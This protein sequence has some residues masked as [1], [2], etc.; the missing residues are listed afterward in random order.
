M[1]NETCWWDSI[2]GE[3]E[4]KFWERVDRSSPSDF[5]KAILLKDALDGRG[6]PINTGNLSG[7]L[8]KKEEFISALKELGGREVLRSV[9]DDWDYDSEEDCVSWN[10]V[11]AFNRGFANVSV[12]SN[13]WAKIMYNIADLELTQ[14]LIVLGKKYFKP[15]T[16]SR[17]IYVIT[18][19]SNGFELTDIGKAALPLERGNY[20]EKVLHDFDTIIGDFKSDTPAGRISIIEGSPGTGKTFLVR[21]LL[22]E[23][24]KSTCVIVPAGMLSDLAGPHLISVLLEAKDTGGAEFPIILIIED[25]DMAII[26]RDAGNM[27]TITSLLNF[28]DGM[29]GSLIDLRIVIT[30]NAKRLDIDEAIKRPGRLSAILKVDSLYDDDAN[31]VLARVLKTT[32]GTLKKPYRDGQA[33]TLAEVYMRAREFGWK[34][35][36]KTSYKKKKS[37]G[38]EGIMTLSS[39]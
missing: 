32:V 8:K 18:V 34:P 10:F 27:S 13:G 9:D 12:S 15:R 23:A 16:E 31:K 4:N 36:P 19:G 25:G 29:L 3:K 33:P 28:G 6:E 24:P 22:D 2:T 35:E 20:T 30:T 7:Y 37:N 38:Q 1:K 21:G 11:L 39:V 5:A 26:S 14:K 17:N